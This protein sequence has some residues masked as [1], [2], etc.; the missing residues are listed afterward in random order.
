VGAYTGSALL[1]LLLTGQSIAIN[2]FN[3]SR[4]ELLLFKAFIAILV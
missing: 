2:P 4:S 1:N 3:S